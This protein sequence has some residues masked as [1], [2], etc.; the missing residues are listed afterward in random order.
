MRQQI[1]LAGG[2]TPKRNIHITTSMD[3]GI[4]EY[5]PQPPP[6]IRQLLGDESVAIIVLEDDGRFDDKIPEIKRIFP[7]AE[8]RH[9]TGQ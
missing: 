2:I 5:I 9:Y 3:G 4:T 8:V 6:W 1:Q 7:E